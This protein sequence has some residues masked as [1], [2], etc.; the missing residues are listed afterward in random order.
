M[1]SSSATFQ[2]SELNIWGP[3]G[4]ATQVLDS[5]FEGN[6]DVAIGLY[7][8][9]DD[10]LVAQRLQFS[11][12]TDEGLLA[13]H[14]QELSYGSASKVINSVSDISVNGVSRNTPGA[15]NGTAEAGIWIGEPVANGVH[16]IRIRNVSIS[17]IE[18]CNNSWNTTFTDLDIA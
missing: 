6:W 9:N 14:S 1:T 18:T 10:G 5:T 15:S 17:G 11:H 16:R 2:D 8:Y 13:S 12:F 7:A 4:E 3:A